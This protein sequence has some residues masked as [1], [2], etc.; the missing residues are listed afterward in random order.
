LVMVTGARVIRAEMVAKL[1]E[2]KQEWN[3][4]LVKITD[5]EGACRSSFRV[6]VE[7]WFR[8]PLFREPTMTS[9]PCSFFSGSDRARAISAVPGA[10]RNRPEP[11]P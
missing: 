5:K 6:S 10:G 9:H 3:A 1:A 4:D 11:G 8:L 2:V 7:P